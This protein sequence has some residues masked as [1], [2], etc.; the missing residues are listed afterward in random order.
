MADVYQIGAYVRLG[1]AAVCIYPTAAGDLCAVDVDLMGGV[2]VGKEQSEIV[3]ASARSQAKMQAHPGDAIIDVP[4]T[5]PEG[6]PAGA[7]PR[8]IIKAGRGELGAILRQ[9]PPIA[10]DAVGALRVQELQATVDHLSG[11]VGA[12]H[13]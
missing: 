4:L 12:R 5:Q 13:R 9:K 2:E 1:Q 3:V 8:A 11:K 7:P 6:P 10:V